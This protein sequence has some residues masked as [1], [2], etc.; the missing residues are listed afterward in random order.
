MECCVCWEPITQLT[1]ASFSTG[2]HCRSDH[3][4]CVRCYMQ[5]I[6]CPLCRYQPME[7]PPI[8]AEVYLETLRERKHHTLNNKIRTSAQVQ[9]YNDIL[10][11]MNDIKIIIN[12]VSAVNL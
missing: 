12:S 5:C 1:M 7:R 2:G 11:Q 4:L 9:E 10:H 3:T 8:Y 6:A